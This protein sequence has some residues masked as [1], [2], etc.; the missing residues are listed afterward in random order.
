MWH[1]TNSRETMLTSRVF[2][3]LCQLRSYAL[4]V[5]NRAVI[6]WIIIIEKEKNKK[7]ELK[8]ANTH[9]PNVKIITLSMWTNRAVCNFHLPTINWISCNKSLSFFVEFV[10]YAMDCD[11]VYIND[12]FSESWDLVNTERRKEEEVAVLSNNSKIKKICLWFIICMW[13]NNTKW[14]IQWM[15]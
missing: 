8:K 3:S 2:R 15:E 11:Q 14:V 7:K 10:K 12:T 6:C 13:I 5:R 9:Y 4:S 1:N